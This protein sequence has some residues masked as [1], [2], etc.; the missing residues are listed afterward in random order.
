MLEALAPMDPGSILQGEDRWSPM[1]EVIK[2]H[3]QDFAHTQPAYAEEMKKLRAAQIRGDALMAS[4]LSSRGAEASRR[5]AAR[6][7]WRHAARRQA[8]GDA[9]MQGG[10]QQVDESCFI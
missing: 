4:K 5:H 3:F 9:L 7:P 6:N 10:T 1:A 2:E 8:E